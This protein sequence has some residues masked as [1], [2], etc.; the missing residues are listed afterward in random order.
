MLFRSRPPDLE[1]HL[2]I[3]NPEIPKATATNFL[4]IIIDDRLN[5]K[6]HIQSVKLSS[7]LS[8]MYKASKLNTTAGVY[9][10]YCSIFQPYISYCNEIWGNNYAS[11]VKCLCII[12]TKAVRLISNAD[13]VAQTKELFKEL[14]IMKFPD[15]FQYKTAILC[16][17]SSTELCLFTCKTDLL[18]ILLLV[19]LAVLIHML[20][21]KQEPT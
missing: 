4:G 15:F 19:V 2:K 16:F 20:W 1:L 11:N 17:I 14:Y 13:R 12:Q 21:F 18:Y 7:I 9:T 10:L 5:W 8:I 3:N 6:T